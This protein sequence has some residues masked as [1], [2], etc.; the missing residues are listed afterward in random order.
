[1]VTQARRAYEQNVKLAEGAESESVKLRALRAILAGVISASKFSDLRRRMAAIEQQLHERPD[2]ARSVVPSDALVTSGHTIQKPE[3]CA[4]LSHF[5]SGARRL[6]G[7]R[8]CSTTQS[9]IMTYDMKSAFSASQKASWRT[10]TGKRPAISAGVHYIPVSF[11]APPNVSVLVVS[12]L[13]EAFHLGTSS[14]P[15][16]ANAKLF[17]SKARMVRSRRLAPGRGRS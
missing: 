14:R 1:M 6:F 9:A 8:S 2:N 15:N 11:P 12:Q 10:C 5:F 13:H 3:K 4:T 7:R 16:P 17:S